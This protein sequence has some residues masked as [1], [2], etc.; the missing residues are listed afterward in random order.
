MMRSVFAKVLSVG[1]LGLA[2]CALTS[3]AW[4]DGP[5]D[6]ALKKVDQAQK[7]YDTLQVKYTVS[8]KEAGRDASAMVVRSSFKG[9]KQV[10]ELLSPGDVKGTKVL[11]LS[12]TE[13]YVWV[14]AYR[15]IR[16]VASHMNEGG[17]MGSCYSVQ[18]M[19]LSQYGKFFTAKIASDAAS[20]MVLALTA[21]PDAARLPY[22]KLELTI[23][24][25]KNLPTKIK[26]YDEAGRHIKTEV[27]DGYFCEGAVCLAKTQRMTDHTKNDKYSQLDL[28]EHKVNPTFSD[29]MFTKR[30]LQH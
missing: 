8:T 11:H 19:N 21:R 7:R 18:D 30:E 23:D 5:G 3:N 15:K 27:R 1:A 29:D 16:R 14:P 2:L 4:A 24:K 12:E 10:T 17:F 22:S 9:Q 6:A 26:Y 13:M 20:T 25:A 28:M